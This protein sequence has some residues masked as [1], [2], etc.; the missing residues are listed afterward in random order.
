MGYTVP[1]SALDCERRYMTQ[2]GGSKGGYRHSVIGRRNVV[3][4]AAVA[5]RFE[6]APRR[7]PPGHTNWQTT[8]AARRG[9]RDW[10]ITFDGDYPA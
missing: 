5:I 7:E 1:W 2:P 9:R 3:S 6:M 4:A 10:A 8:S